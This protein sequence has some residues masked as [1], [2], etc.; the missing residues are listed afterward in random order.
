M[1][2]VKNVSV[3]ASDDAPVE[4]EVI[5]ANDVP[6]G[7]PVVVVDRL[8]HRREGLAYRADAAKGAATHYILAARDWAAPRVGTARER[9]SSDVLPRVNGAAESARSRMGSAVA[10]AGTKA[11]GAVAAARSTKPTKGKKQVAKGRKQVARTSRLSRL[12]VTTTPKG[13]QVKRRRGRALLFGALVGAAAAAWRLWSSRRSSTPT[14]A[15][16]VG[17]TSPASSASATTTG[18]PLLA[19]QSPSGGTTGTSSTQASGSARVIDLGGG[20]AAGGGVGGTGT[21]GGGAG[22]LDLPGDPTQVDETAASTTPASLRSD[23]GP[24]ISDT[25]EAGRRARAAEAGRAA[26]DQG[27]GPEGSRP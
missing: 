24:G 5:S 3:D 9:V 25:D 23:E 22:S 21:T 12:L 10:E 1:A 14:D 27:S 4:V 11:S 15:V 26:F 20:G 17:T 13:R 18:G 7:T 6:A 2:K 19:Q 16:P 8:G